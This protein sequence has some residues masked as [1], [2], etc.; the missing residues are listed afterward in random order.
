[1]T[2]WIDSIDLFAGGGGTSTG[3]AQACQELNR[4]VRLKAFNHWPRSI[5]THKANHPWAQHFCVRVD[6]VDPNTFVGDSKLR[7]LAASPECRWHSNARGGRP[8]N[9]QERVSAWSVLT[10]VEA[11]MP[12]TVLIENVKEF[13]HWGPIHPLDHP[14]KT[15]RGRPIKEKRGT[16]YEAFLKNLR[17][18]GYNVEQE[19]LC[20][21]DYG[22]PTSRERLFILAH[23]GN[24][25]IHWPTPTHTGDRQIHPERLPYVPARECIDFS[26]PTRPIWGRKTSTG[27]PAD[28]EPSTL[29]RIAAGMEKFWG[30]EFDSS[31]PCRGLSLEPFILVFRNNQTAHS[32]RDPLAT[33]TTRGCNFGLVQPALTPFLI[34]QQSCSAPRSVKD[35]MPTI[36]SAGAISLIEP[37]LVKFH[38]NHGHRE[39]GTNR[40]YSLDEPIRTLDTQN[41]FGLVQP[42][43]CPTT[44]ADDLYLLVPHFRMLAPRELAA[45]MSFP[46][47]YIFT[48]NIGE[49][50]KQIGNAVC[51]G[52]ARAI[53]REILA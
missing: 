16:I 10:W 43:F 23:R 28:L 35:P 25:P 4:E 20:A 27:K 47:D 36:S 30:I 34:G 2:N 32:L 13:R 48:G 8:I 38:G 22:V 5:Q 51:P 37:F 11:T 45:A 19:I 12:E 15:K 53:F 50:K 29:A 14:D 7:V 26:I 24:R 17:A 41:R 39:S 46:S 18:Y 40:V 3:L 9:D 6:H 52:L 42:Q 31:K 1:M 44:Q 49:Q 21:A 33:I